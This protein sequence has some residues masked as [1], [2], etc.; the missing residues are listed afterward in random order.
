MMKTFGWRGCSGLRKAQV[1]GALIGVLATIVS[2]LIVYNSIV[3]P[4]HRDSNEFGFTLS[5]TVWLLIT[6]P[7][8]FLAGRFGMA[9]W[10]PNDSLE[11]TVIICASILLN[12]GLTALLASPFGW[13]RDWLNPRPA[14]T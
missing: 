4:Q 2:G 1:I 9:F 7:A 11:Y 5:E 12:G 3:F 13:L 10:R 14:E 6:L 8:R